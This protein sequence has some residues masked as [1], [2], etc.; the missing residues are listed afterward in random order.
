MGVNITSLLSSKVVSVSDFSGKVVA[1]DA[2]IFLHNF[3]HNIRNP[4][5][6]LF[7]DSN[8]NVTSHLIGI[9]SRV[10]NLLS[11]NVK[12]VFVFDGKPPVMK[13]GELLKRG[14]YREKAKE[15][16]EQAKSVGDVESMKKY[17]SSSVSLDKNIVEDAKKLI[18]LLGCPVVQAP[19]E[20]EAQASFL[21]KNGDAVAV[22]SQDADVLL[23]GS[24]FLVRNFFSSG[25]KVFSGSSKEIF[26]L[27]FSL[28]ETLRE[29]NISLD[30]LIFLSMLIG[31]DYNVGGIKKIGPVKALELVKK[32]ENPDELF[33]FVNWSDFFDFSWKEVFDLFKNPEVTKNYS[34]KFSSCDEEG[35]K[36]FL[37]DERDFSVDRVSKALG[38]LE[39]FK[40]SL[41]QK[42][43]SGF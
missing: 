23:F 30:Q 27:E 36:K 21:V 35:L 10:P 25:K 33:S 4:D 32:F 37:I 7:S 13:G 34:L 40:S 14:A 17:A 42:S 1:I 20:A 41:R 29:Q 24:P 3:L 38:S 19:S 15:L 26:P 6:S 12:P 39:K 5:G 31:T 16:Y 18:G 43:L 9:L 28:D 2:S 11:Q 8:G 22:V